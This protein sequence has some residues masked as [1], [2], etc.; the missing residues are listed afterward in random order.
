[1]VART[2]VI[3][4]ALTLLIIPLNAQNL[5]SKKFDAGVTA[6]YWFSG[7]VIIDGVDVDKDGAFLLRAF[8]DAYVIPQLAFGGYFNYSPYSEAGYSLNLFEFGMAIKPRFMLAPDMAIKPGVNFGY[9]FTTSDFEPAEINAF[10]LNLSVEIQKQLSGMLVFGEIGFLAQPSGGNE[11]V[12][13]TF[14]PIFYIGGGI[15]F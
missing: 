13:V 2:L 11:N 9:R 5:E 15:G 4:I 7:T 3:G 12:E 1:M 6:G 14:A 8:G 10:G